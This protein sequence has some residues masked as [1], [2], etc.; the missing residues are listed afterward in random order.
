MAIIKLSVKIAPTI[1]NFK[2]PNTVHI[3][4]KLLRLQ[5]MYLYA[6]KIDQRIQISSVCLCMRHE[7]IWSNKTE[8]KE[9]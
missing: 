7:S 3:F 8:R 9:S 1:L 5:L 6:C 4:S 2:L